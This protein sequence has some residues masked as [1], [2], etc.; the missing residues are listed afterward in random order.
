MSRSDRPRILVVEDEALIAM[1]VEAQ[2]RALDFS[3][4]GPVGWLGQAM[5]IARDEPLD[6]ALLDVN[7]K[8][9]EVF[10]VAEILLARGV[11]VV[12]ATGYGPENRPADFRSLTWLHK[13]FSA[14]QL[15]PWCCA[16][17][18]PSGSAAPLGELS[19]PALI[20]RL[21]KIGWSTLAPGAI[22][23]RLATP[24]FTSSTARIGCSTGPAFPRTARCRRRSGRWCRSRR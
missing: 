3:V 5:E 6:G 1:E 24:A 13:P 22:P 23:S 9:G 15:G 21:V 14:R 7:V 12:L 4:V 2:L 11:P 20:G 10:P 16:S 17:S 19:R 8:G 18:R